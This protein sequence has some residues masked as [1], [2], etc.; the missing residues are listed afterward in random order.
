M[1]N[2]GETAELSGVLALVF[3]FFGLIA[4][5]FAVARIAPRPMEGMAWLNT[6]IVY[7]ALPALF[8]K[9]L[10]ETPVEELTNVRYIGAAVLAVV[11][12]FLG[13][14]LPALVLSRGRIGEA[15]IQGLASAYGNIGYMGPGIALLALGPRAAVP[16]VLIFT[17]E[18]IFHFTVAPLMMALRGGGGRSVGVLLLEVVRRILTHP[19][20]VATIVGVGAAVLEWTPPLALAR[21]IESL[22][23]AAAP[24]A[25][26]AMGVTLALRPVSRFPVAL[27]AIVP[28][29]LVLHPLL[30]WALMLWLGPFD[31]VWVQSAILLA[32]L[33]TATNVY[34]I[35][36]QYDEWVNRASAAILVSTLISILTVTALLY[37]LRAGWVPLEGSPL[38]LLEAWRTGEP[39]PGN[40]AAPKRD[41]LPFRAP[42]A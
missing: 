12:V 30:C 28:A 22:A 23:G 4:L 25:L 20:I 11:L 9:L 14:L 36:A 24:C 8:F 26:F 33:P 32:A 5:G 35:A 29:K 21:M 38:D 37:A 27:G 2:E 10:A 16:V 7:V 42:D 34:V 3:P 41:R 1:R 40:D 31:P 15:T 39:P 18:N 6:F 19:F 13:V 17:F